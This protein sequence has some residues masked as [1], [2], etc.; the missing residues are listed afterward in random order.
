MENVSLQA[1]NLACLDLY[2]FGKR[3]GTSFHD[4]GIR[5]GIDFHDLCYKKPVWKVKFLCT[6]LVHQET[7]GNNRKH[8]PC[9]LVP[10]KKENKYAFFATYVKCWVCF[11]D[12]NIH[13]HNW[14]KTTPGL[15]TSKLISS[16]NLYIIC[17]P[18]F[19]HYLLI[20][21]V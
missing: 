18:A 13:N 11:L 17:A 20:G 2:D 21:F 6:A 9:T 19:Y 3:N 15:I 14:V 1:E 4:L 16:A 5:N 7:L 8:V 10:D 12:G